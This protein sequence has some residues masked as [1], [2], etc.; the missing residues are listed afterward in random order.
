V[1]GPPQHLAADPHRRHAGTHR[2]DGRG[3][4][5]DSRRRRSVRHR[6]RVLGWPFKWLGL[7]GD[8]S[9][10]PATRAL[11]ALGP[12]YIK[13]GQ[14]LS[15][16]PDVVGDE[17]ARSCGCCRTSCR[18]FPT[19]RPSAM[20]ERELGAGRRAVL[21]VQRARSPR[22]PSRR[23]TR[24][25]CATRR[26]G[27]G[28][29]AAPGHRAR[30]PQGYR[31][32]LPRRAHDR[33]ALARRAP[34]APDGRDRAFRGRGDGRAGPAAG[35]PPRPREFAANTEGRCPGFQLPPMEGSCRGAG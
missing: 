5:G 7:K 25:G 16:R 35:K 15:T 18:P 24:R 9:M 11:T 6:A 10:P 3:A 4:R 23:C 13:F 17:L 29:G 30:V 26:G 2:R 28:Q 32:L 22:P 33:D 34:P 8:P 12:A 27:G 1:R 19:T 21:G 14:I 20:I 31:R